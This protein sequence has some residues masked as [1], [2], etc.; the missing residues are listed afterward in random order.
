MKITSR[1]IVWFTLVAFFMIIVG[2][3]LSYYFFKSVFDQRL[4]QEIAETVGSQ[5]ANLLAGIASRPVG[6]I[7]V[8]E[9][10]ALE[11]IMK[12]EPRILGLIYL[13]PKANIRWYKGPVSP[14]GKETFINKTYD[15]ALAY[16]LFPT[17]AVATAFNTK[18]PK[19]Y[20]YADGEYYDIAFP[21]MARED[22]AGVLAVQVSRANIKTLTND[23]MFKYF[24][25]SAFIMLLMGFALY[26]F[27]YFKI[28]V[29]LEGLNKAVASVPIRD[30][31]LYYPDRSDEIGDVAG[32]VR[33]L[34]GRVQG[35][36]TQ[37][38]ARMQEKKDLEKIW[39]Q[40]LL[41]VSIG[42]GVRAIIVDSNNNVM[43][44]NFELDVKKEGPIHILDLFDSA[45]QDLIEIIGRAMDSPGKVLKKHIVSGGK[46]F[47]IRVSEL[48][49]LDKEARTMIVFEPEE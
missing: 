23:A 29:P 24:F 3:A 30:M 18:T 39:W 35:E 42:R 17:Y 44:T 33:V 28:V 16:N 31:V 34:L 11:A 49:G 46:K 6:A 14:I 10:D 48:P 5:T 4:Q 43:F 25:G 21:L 2:S 12:R 19:V 27:V 20:S 32:S 26:I 8:P 41:G 38:F 37:N 15:E 13:G 7:T 36:L 22:L 1:W 47:E 45:Q 9:V 40:S